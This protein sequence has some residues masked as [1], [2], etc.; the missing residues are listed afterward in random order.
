MM[1]TRIL[2]AV[3]I[4]VALS[5]C[6]LEVGQGPNRA[7]WNPLETQLTSATVGSLS[8]AWQRVVSGAP[9]EAMIVGSGAFVPA[10][11]ALSRLDVST[12]TV[13]WSVS[14][15]GPPI[16]LGGHI[17]T[18]V[19]VDDPNGNPGSYQC[20]VLGLDPT[21]GAVATGLDVAGLIFAR[22]GPAGDCMFSP[23]VGTGS[24]IVLAF[25]SRFISTMSPGACG[26]VPAPPVYEA[27][28]AM[29]FDLGGGSPPPGWITGTS[30]RI[31]AATTPPF[32]PLPFGMTSASGSLVFTTTGTHVTAINAANGAGVWGTD[33]GESVI[34]PVIAT[35]R[36]DVALTTTSGRLVVLNG[37]TGNVEWS[38]SVSGSLTVPPAAT[39]N[40]I[41]VAAPNGALDAF[42]ATGCGGSV[43]APSW[44]ATT[45]SPASV[46]PSIGADVVY[47]GSADGTVTAFPAAGCGTSTCS[48]LW[49][50]TTGSPI[51]GA[52]AVA[53]GHLVVGSADGTV[54]AFALP[55]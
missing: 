47:V 1:R 24:R 46:R 12:G 7:A 37:T 21:T 27:S 26:P 3:V 17:W 48:A 40:V 16:F 41:F 28:G 30:S 34:E 29:G 45:S 20:D 13:A 36:G 38:A 35:T 23:V 55:G 52:P 53:S 19:G 11:G 9:G 42:D 14:S 54:T 6:W 32:L 25:S 50:G 15:G 49:T 4:T 10:G 31:C 5:G 33:V 22:F 44:T 51:T 2:V 43:C 8:V 18:A 39:S